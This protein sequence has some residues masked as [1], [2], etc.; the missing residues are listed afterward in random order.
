[1]RDIEHASAEEFINNINKVCG[2]FHDCTGCP[3]HSYYKTGFCSHI[4]DLPDI[5]NKV[6]KY[7][8]NIKEDR[9]ENLLIKCFEWSIEVGGQHTEDLIRA[10]GI[11]SKELDAIGYPKDEFPELHKEA[12]EC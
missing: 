4:E 1:M 9:L 3:L 8:N 6:R 11:T 10:T 2:D 12:E 5:F 7:M